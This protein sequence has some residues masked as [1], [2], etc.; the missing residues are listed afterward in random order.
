[1]SVTVLSETKKYLATTLLEAESFLKEK[2][3]ELGDYVKS[4]SLTKKTRKGIDYYVV[5]IT[6]QYYTEAELME[7]DW[8]AIKE[9][10]TQSC[11]FL[12]LRK[13]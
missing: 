9:K 5:V 2:K 8:W 4:S 11:T 6:T 7:V 12:R 3:K 10:Y 1:M 13:V